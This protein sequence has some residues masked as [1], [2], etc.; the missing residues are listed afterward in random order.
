MRKSARQLLLAANHRSDPIVSYSD[1]D[2]IR[3]N[4][5]ESDRTRP[6]YGQLYSWPYLI[7][8]DLKYDPKFT[9]DPGTIRPGHTRSDN[10]I[11]RRIRTELDEVIWSYDRVTIILLQ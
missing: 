9:Y 11:I 1:T 7:G 8:Y 2:Q 10:N 3:I 4:E 6:T 5:S